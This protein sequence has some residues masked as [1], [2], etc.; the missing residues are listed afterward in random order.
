MATRTALR[1]SAVLG[2][3]A[4][5]LVWTG[6]CSH[7]PAHLRQTKKVG[8]VNNIQHELLELVQIPSPERRLPAAATPRRT[9]ASRRQ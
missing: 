9:R 6:A 3:L 2:V 4:I 5:A 1:R 8:L 7:E